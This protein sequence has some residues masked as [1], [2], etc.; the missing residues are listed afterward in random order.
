M[1]MPILVPL[2]SS[3]TIC[4]PK[5]FAHAY[6]DVDTRTTKTLSL[7]QTKLRGRPDLPRKVLYAQNDLKPGLRSKPLCS[8]RACV[9]NET[10]C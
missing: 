9:L 10:I 1:G 8:M 3:C 6:L 5:Y 2:K 7:N 4:S